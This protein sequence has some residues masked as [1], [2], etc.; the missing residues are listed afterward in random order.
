MGL[1]DGLDPMALAAI[2]GG[3]GGAEGAGPDM[4]A[5]TEDA[6]R[7]SQIAQ[8]A[9]T[10]QQPLT[11]TPVQTRSFAPTPPGPEFN[12]SPVAPGTVPLPRPA[13]VIPPT[14]PSVNPNDPVR[15][16]G[17]RPTGNQDNLGAALTGNDTAAL[18]Q[19]AVGPTSVG[20]APLGPQPGTSGATDMSARAKTTPEK[21]GT[22]AQALKGVA[23]PK[24]PE[25]QKISSPNP[26]RPTGTIAPGLQQLLAM[27]NARG[28]GRVPTLRG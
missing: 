25:L 27:L 21:L 19:P 10:A 26:P 6:L 8:Q 12:P 28:A 24:P 1:F 17:Q 7:Q 23:A 4:G 14:E 5:L 16:Y 9:L 22:L 15:L 11:P 3:A 13:P 18:T 2:F 20:G